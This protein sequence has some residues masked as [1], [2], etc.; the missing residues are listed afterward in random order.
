MVRQ[1]N[2]GNMNAQR[3]QHITAFVLL[4]IGAAL[5]A[6]GVLSWMQLFWEGAILLW[7]GTG[8]LLS[9]RKGALISL[10]LIPV[11]LYTTVFPDI[12]ILAPWLGW[13]INIIWG[14]FLFLCIRFLE[15]G[16]ARDRLSML[17]AFPLVYSFRLI[18]P[19][20]DFY[21]NLEPQK[22]YRL[23]SLKVIQSHFF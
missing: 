13:L 4:A 3:K 23:H 2:E 7:L 9:R 18:D 12:P 15:M 8:N 11:V 10:F 14:G 21:A 20:F 1:D 17:L 19:M 22:L 5:I 6:L 16:P